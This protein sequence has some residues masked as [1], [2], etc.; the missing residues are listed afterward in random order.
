MLN[1]LP[2][3]LSHISDCFTECHNKSEN[4]YYNLSDWIPKIKFT[5]PVQ[6]KRCQKCD[7]F[8]ILIAIQEILLKSNTSFYEKVSKILKSY[9]LPHFPSHSSISD[10]NKSICIPFL[11]I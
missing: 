2:H 7:S 1:L 4:F 9:E 5:T 8:P 10:I 6:S 3:W 11:Y